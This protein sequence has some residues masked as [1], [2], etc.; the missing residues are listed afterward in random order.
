[1][2][3]ALS[4]KKNSKLIYIIGIGLLTGTLDGLSAIIYKWKV[5][6]ASIFKF[7]ASGVYGHAA[8]FAGGTKMILMG[9]LFHYLIAFLFTIFF[10]LLHPMFYS[11]FRNKLITAIFY[12]IVIWAIMNIAVVPLSNIPPRPFNLVSSLINCGILMIT[13]G[14]PISIIATGFYFYKRK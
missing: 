11:W 12:G 4:T 6:A 8:A 9:V 13:L 10:F 1:M 7:I 14:L 5:P 2:A 3:L